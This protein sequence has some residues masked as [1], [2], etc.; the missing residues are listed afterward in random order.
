M[1]AS[2]RPW[3]RLAENLQAILIIGLPFLVIKGESALRFDIPTLRLHFF[4]ISLWMEEFFIVLIGVIFFSL[5]IIL[6]T[7]LFGRVWC[8]WLCPQTVIVDFTYFMDSAFKKGYAYKIGALLVVIIASVIMGANLIWYFVS[9]Y[10]FFERLLTNQP[11]ET[12]WGFWIVLSLILF[13]NFAFLRHKFCATVCPYA[14]LQSVLFDD[15]TLVIAFDNERSGECM[16]CDACVRV[17]PVNIDIKKG[18]SQ[19]CI[20]CAEC[21][22]KCSEMLKKKNRDGLVRYIFGQENYNG[23]LLRPK[24]ILLG[25]LTLCFFIFAVYLLLFRMPFDLVVMPNNDF[26]TRISD[27]G[28]LI[29]SYMVSVENRDRVPAGFGLKAAISGVYVEIKPDHI[30]LEAGEHRKIQVFVIIKPDMLIKEQMQLRIA[31]E[32]N[33]SG[34]SIVKRASIRRPEKL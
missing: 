28:D 4:G 8:G 30:A 20:A 11:G 29:S 6:M 7:V 23:K 26:K 5:L 16:H 15:K 2:I 21:V 31:V 24:V 14:K 12:I 27:K 34:K 33:K 25:A 18:L 9:P 19:A 10:E 17:C 32:S 3:R 13:L 1:S 22:D